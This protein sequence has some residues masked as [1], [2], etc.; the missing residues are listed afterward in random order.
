MIREADRDLLLEI[1]GPRVNENYVVSH[2]TTY[3]V[4]G[5]AAFHFMAESQ[6]D[7]EAVVKV[8]AATRIPVVVLGRGSNVLIADEGFDG[9]VLQLGDLATAIEFD[10][11]AKRGRVAAGSSVALPVLARQCAKAGLRGFE[12]AVGVPGTIGG[13]VRM[14]AGGHGSDMAARLVSVDIFDLENGM[15]ST[16]SASELG[17]R[18]RGSDL[19]D[20]EVVLKAVLDLTPGPA[21]EAMKQI[22]DIVKWR[23]ENQPGG[24]NAGSVFIN[25]VAHGVAAGAL[26]DECGLR[27]LRLGSAEVSTK[28]ANFI[29][30]DPDGRARDVVELMKKVQLIVEERTGLRLRSEIRLIGFEEAVRGALA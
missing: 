11:D 9:L 30:A 27:G 25:P 1:L 22:E 14:N 5:T 19:T 10:V 29:Q 2:L 26:I 17:L 8:R 21:D 24:Q 15:T 20:S 4:G 12:W 18:F 23:R 13:A 28:H 16:R 3:R 6:R 7:L